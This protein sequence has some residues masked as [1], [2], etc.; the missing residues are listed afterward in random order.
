LMSALSAWFTTLLD[1]PWDDMN[2]GY[3]T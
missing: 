1:K 2:Q 3:G